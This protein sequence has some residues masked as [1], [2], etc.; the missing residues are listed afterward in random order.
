MNSIKRV[1]DRECD[2]RLIHNFSLDDIVLIQPERHLTPCP[3]WLLPH[4][5]WSRKTP[6]ATAFARD[7]L[8]HKLAALVNPPR[9]IGLG[10][11]IA[12]INLS[13]DYSATY[14]ANILNR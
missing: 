4:D 14:F 5:Q 1:V 3:V 8:M 6:H 7:E 9:D 13:Y 10:H 2:F 11:Q 12:V